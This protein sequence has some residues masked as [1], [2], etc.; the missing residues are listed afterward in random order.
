MRLIDIDKW[1]EILN[2]IWRHKLRTL[3]TAFGVAWGIFILVLMLGA[4]S[5]LK[6][7]FQYQF[8]DDNLNSIWIWGGRTSK[9]FNGL[10]EGRSID[11]NNEDFDYINFQI[12]DL[13]AST[14]RFYLSGTTV[15]KYKNTA[16]SFRNRAVHPG[17]LIL[18]NNEMIEGRYINEADMQQYRKVAVI[19]R[20]VKEQLM[21]DV[22][23]A[24]GEEISL[25]GTVYTVV[26]VFTDSGGE[27]EEKQIYIP[28]STAQRVYSAGDRIDQMM[29]AGGDRS[30]EEMEVLSEQLNQILSTRKQFDPD[31]NQ[32]LWLNNRAEDFEEF[33]SLFRTF[34]VIT[35]II[36]IFSII[37]GVIGVSN[38]MLIIVKDRTKEIGIRKAIGATPSSIVGMILQESILITGVAGYIGM[39][40]GVGMIAL[41]QGV[42]EEYFRH[43]TVDVGIVVAAT[44]V[45]VVAGALAGLLPALKAAHINP[46]I[47]MKSD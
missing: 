26:G 39:A 44:V 35:W 12:P 17:H 42:E 7:S 11:F 25:D 45:L 2:S 20:V 5:G 37:A 43:P 19:G 31:D 36:G 8:A 34:G 6:T 22:E 4:I 3:L 14:G 10:T 32:A 9:P 18:E 15:T 23:D 27:N 40:A 41:V 1:Q 38:I 16:L 46:V 28:I 21:P 24:V 30:V 13:E 33:N 29:F 47:A